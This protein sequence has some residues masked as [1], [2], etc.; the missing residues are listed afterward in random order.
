MVSG[1]QPVTAAQ[2]RTPAGPIIE[3]GLM[4]P[5]FFCKDAIRQ[6]VLVE[7]AVDS[8]GDGNPDVV[9]A[10]IRPKETEWSLQLPVITD[11]SPYYSTLGRGNESRLKKCD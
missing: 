2:A 3:S 1:L 10:G 9:A 7:P 11:F 8:D 4:Q 5:V 6:H